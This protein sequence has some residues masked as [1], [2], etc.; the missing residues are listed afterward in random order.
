MDAALAVG[1]AVSLD[2]L[3]RWKKLLT[4]LSKDFRKVSGQN[5]IPALQLAAAADMAER[6]NTM[7]ESAT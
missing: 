1:K 4:T 3:A 6:R 2:E 7:S 5:Q